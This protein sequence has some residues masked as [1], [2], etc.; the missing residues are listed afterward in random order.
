MHGTDE[1]RVQNSTQKPKHRWEE[2]TRMD[3]REVGWE[4]IDWRHLAQ[5][6]DQWQAVV[7]T[8]MNLQVP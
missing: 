3:L 7:N 6:G 1:E 5:D 2:N 4:G 8:A